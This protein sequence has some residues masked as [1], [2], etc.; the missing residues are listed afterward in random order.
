LALLLFADLCEPNPEVRPL[1]VIHDALIVEVPDASKDKFFSDASN[2]H[3]EGTWFPTK[4][5][6][7]DN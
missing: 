4:V 5:E 2:L 7:L 6:E 3:F 1:V